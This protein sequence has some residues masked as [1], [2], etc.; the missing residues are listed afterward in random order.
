MVADIAVLEG[1]PYPEGI[2]DAEE[3]LSHHTQHL[4]V[5]AVELIKAGPGAGLSQAGKELAHEAVVQPLTAVEHHTIC[6][7]RLAQVL[8]AANTLSSA[9]QPATQSTHGFGSS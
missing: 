4:N 2:L 7:Q 1:G 3:L 5:D 9:S 6:A 8:L